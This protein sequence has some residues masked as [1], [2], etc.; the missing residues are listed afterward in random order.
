MFALLIYFLCL[1]GCGKS[2]TEKALD[3]GVEFFASIQRAD[4]AICDTVNPLF[5]IWETVEAATAIYAVRKD[6]ADETFPRGD[7]I[8]RGE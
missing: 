7:E 8:S 3:Q 5:D 6:T 4:G 2:P 1:V